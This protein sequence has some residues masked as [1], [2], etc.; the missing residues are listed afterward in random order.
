[1]ENLDMS[2]LKSIASRCS[3]YS[4]NGLQLTS[5][6]NSND[7]ACTNCEHY[8]NSKCSLGLIDQILTNLR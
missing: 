7:V 3:E 8:E 1:M 6:T 2:Q 4:P 5:S